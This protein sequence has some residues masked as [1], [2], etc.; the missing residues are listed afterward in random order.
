[1]ARN[2]DGSG[3]YIEFTH[4]TGL[5]VVGG[6]F[7]IAGWVNPTSFT[8]YE[9]LYSQRT[10]SNGL[11]FFPRGGTNSR[12]YWVVGGT[13]NEFYH[14]G[15]IATGS[16]Q[17]VGMRRVGS[18]LTFFIDGVQLTYSAGVDTTSGT[19]TDTQNPRIGND[20]A[21]G[22][23]NWNG[24]QAELAI[25]SND[26]DNNEMVSLAKGFSPLLVRPSELVFYVP[27]TGGR[28]P[29][30]DL[31]GGRAGTVTN[32]TAS[33]HPR[34]YYPRRKQALVPTAAAA[35]TTFGFLR[36]NAGLG[37]VGG[38]PFSRSNAGLGVLA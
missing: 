29:E 16:W 33:S 28:D 37:A 30:P 17:H 7:T 22:G 31:I 1:M 35:A 2:F 5:N 32:A 11:A 13:E 18:Q 23:A 27:M 15:S 8:G 14:T 36:D 4:D 19:T 25:W 20:R 34:V 24:H 9:T 12:M 21:A 6:D 10:G 3:D 38:G 26:L